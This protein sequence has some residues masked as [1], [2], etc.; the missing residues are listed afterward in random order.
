MK[1]IQESHDEK[2][3]NV[4]DC[5]SPLYDS[6]ELVAVSHVV[7]RHLMVLP[8]LS[9]SRNAATNELSHSD[10]QKP[11]RDGEATTATSSAGKSSVLSFLRWNKRKL[12][13]ESKVQKAKRQKKTGISRI[14]QCRISSWKKL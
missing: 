13:G 2:A 5:G 14:F 6:Y 4:W 8:Y 12:D 10:D 1:R 11:A 3:I 9:G 7:E